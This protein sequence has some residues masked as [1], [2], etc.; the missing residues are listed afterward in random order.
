MHTRVRAYTQI[1]GHE[2]PARSSHIPQWRFF[3]PSSF[4]ASSTSVSLGDTTVP[5]KLG[6]KKKN[7]LLDQA[8]IE[9]TLE[10]LNGVRSL[11]LGGASRQVGEELFVT[12]VLPRPASPK[13]R[14]TTEKYRDRLYRPRRLRAR[15]TNLRKKKKTYL[16]ITRLR[17]IWKIT[18]RALISTF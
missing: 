18:H 16:L 13:S 15:N 9:R 10:C 3:F 8:R 12:C 17:I 11:V 5:R 6:D 7:K 2:R 14:R 4:L 1:N